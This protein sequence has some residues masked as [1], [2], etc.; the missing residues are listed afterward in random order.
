M[1]KFLL[2]VALTA[3]CWAVLVGGLVALGHGT[4]YTAA[5]IARTVFA[6]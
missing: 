3:A 6:Q 4:H 2:G 1:L 5:H